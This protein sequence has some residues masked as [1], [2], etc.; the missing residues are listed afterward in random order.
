MNKIHFELNNVG[1]SV[2]SEAII[3]VPQSESVDVEREMIFNNNFVLF[4]KEGSKK[5]PYFALMVDDENVL[6]TDAE[7]NNE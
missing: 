2:K 1:G 4:L 7:N 3:E 5:Q 6:I